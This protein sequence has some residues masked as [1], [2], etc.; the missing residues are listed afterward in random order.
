MLISW[1]YANPSTR[2]YKPIYM[3]LRLE[4]LRFLPDTDINKFLFH[5][6]PNYSAVILKYIREHVSV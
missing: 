6:N 2:T 3:Y 5:T 4:S 1:F